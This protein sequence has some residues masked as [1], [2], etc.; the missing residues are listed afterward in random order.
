MT[1]FN[2]A[3]YKPSPEYQ[4]SAPPPGCPLKRISKAKET[5]AI[6]K[7]QL[8]AV[9]VLAM[10]AEDGLDKLRVHIFTDFSDLSVFQPE[11]NAIQIVVVEPILGF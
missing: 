4:T 1:V 6:A 2:G 11:H 8:P 9:R 5:P 7:Q 3:S 10:L